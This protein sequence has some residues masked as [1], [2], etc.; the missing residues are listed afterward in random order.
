MEAAR[1]AP[2]VTTP[3]AYSS[4]ANWV[5]ASLSVAS[6]RTTC[7]RSAEA[8]C[9]TSGLQSIPSTS[10]PLASNSVAMLRPKRPKPMTTALCGLPAGWAGEF[11]VEL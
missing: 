3:Q 9:T 5:S 4:T 2:I 10:T 11:G 8:R 7:R 1:S 6:A